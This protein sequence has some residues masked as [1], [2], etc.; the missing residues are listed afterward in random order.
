MNHYEEIERQWRKGNCEART[1]VWAEAL[2]A[3]LE[4]VR[5]HRDS[6]HEWD[7]LKV[8]ISYSM[9]TQRTLSF[10]L[11]YLGQEVGQI[12]P[13]R[14]G[15]RL[16]ISKCQQQTNQDSFG[17]DPREWSNMDWRSE[18][19]R[20]F[21]EYF[22]NP[23]TKL[24]RSEEHW[25]ESR[26]ITEMRKDR[27]VEKFQGTLKGIQPVLLESIPFQCPVPLGASGGKPKISPR[28]NIDILAR[29]AGRRL[30]IW[31]LKKR[32]TFAHALDQVY[33]YAVSV[34]KMLRSGKGATWYTLFNYQGAVPEFLELDAVVA[35]T[36]DQQGALERSLRRFESP[37]DLKT[38]RAHI[39]LV[40]A[41]YH[42]DPDTD[43]LTIESMV[44]LKQT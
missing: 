6:F 25:I 26:F 20:A 38:E 2:E 36:S 32:G 1:N 11:R 12:R 19:A 15:L 40:A 23:R 17:L 5:E 4:T 16:V 43:A 22:K 44:P 10:S 21:R 34:A 37:L 27:A 7:P 39:N 41:Y 33:I 42:W 3:S 18:E 9:A 29:R 30:S 24:P 8:Y 28:A 35:I 13:S 14:N 31:E